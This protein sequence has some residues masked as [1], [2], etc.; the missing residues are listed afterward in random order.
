MPFHNIQFISTVLFCNQLSGIRRL[1][2]WLHPHM[3]IHKQV[4]ESDLK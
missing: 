2:I 1:P 3:A 4:F